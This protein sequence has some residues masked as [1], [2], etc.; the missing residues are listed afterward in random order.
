MKT[1]PRLCRILTAAAIMLA[2]P[3]LADVKVI[4][5]QYS[6][7]PLT[8]STNFGPAVDAVNVGGVSLNCDG[9]SFTG[10]TVPENSTSNQVIETTPFNVTLSSKSGNLAAVVIA[11]GDAL[12]HSEVYSLGFQDVSLLISGLDPKQTYQVQ[13]LHGDMRGEEW[14]RY[15]EAP[16]TFT[17][18]KGKTATTP[19]AFNTVANSNQY[20][21]V[22]VEVS[23]STSLQY[24]MPHSSGTGGRGPSFS[25]FVVLQKP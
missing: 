17:D 20:A 3:A 1:S 23:R 4:G 19:L 10:Q 14:A 12:F 11:G 9:V 21:I 25:G 13:F 7:S 15:N 5:T 2:L 18:S 8:I 6:G 16:Q 22:T 24:D